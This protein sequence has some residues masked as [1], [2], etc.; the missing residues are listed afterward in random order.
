MSSG[1]LYAFNYNRQMS[2]REYTFIKKKI[3]LLIKQYTG[4]GDI[5]CRIIF[6]T[7]FNYLKGCIYT[8]QVP[9]HN[10]D[11]NKLIM[12]AINVSK[13]LFQFL[14]KKIH[15]EELEMAENSELEESS[16]FSS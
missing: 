2:T 1:S 8:Q 14:T 13:F 16:F 7:K 3:N 15:T 5:S 9:H 4:N 6:L 11:I 12:F 10:N